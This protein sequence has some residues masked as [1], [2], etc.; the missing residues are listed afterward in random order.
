[1]TNRKLTTLCR[2]WCQLNSWKWPKDLP[3][4]RPAVCSREDLAYMA[5]WDAVLK[6][7][8]YKVALNYWREVY[9]PEQEKR[10]KARKK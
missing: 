5:A 7:I 6:A 1:M 2:W 9:Y 4:E 8:A 3:M 10:L